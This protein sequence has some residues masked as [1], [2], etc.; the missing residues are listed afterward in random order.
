M[1]TIITA[2]DS[3]RKA[4]QE[5]FL[6]RISDYTLAD[7]KGTAS[8]WVKEMLRSDK[9]VAIWGSELGMLSTKYTKKNKPELALIISQRRMEAGLLKRKF[10]SDPKNT[11]TPHITVLA[12]EK[13]GIDLV[14]NTL[15][16][17]DAIIGLE[18]LTVLMSI[19]SKLEDQNKKQDWS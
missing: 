12:K 11:Q 8:P 13:Y 2:Q 19:N 5:A 4:A 18:I 3:D 6:E 9:Y 16:E 15:Q 14:G 1:D 17:I 10:H 7:I